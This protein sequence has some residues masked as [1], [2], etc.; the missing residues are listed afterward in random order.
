MSREVLVNVGVHPSKMIDTE[1]D[2]VSKE[3]FD[4]E[5]GYIVDLLIDEG[6]LGPDDKVS[7]AIDHTRRILL[8]IDGKPKYDQLEEDE[9]MVSVGNFIMIF[10]L[11][12]GRS[13]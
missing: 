12:F 10:T 7:F 13:N 11:D 8:T 4:S 3:L 1:T 2:P 6:I 9:A 5:S